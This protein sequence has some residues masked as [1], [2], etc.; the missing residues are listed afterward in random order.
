M[1]KNFPK[2]SKG[3]TFEFS[4]ILILSKG[5]TFHN[6][7]KLVTQIHRISQ[8]KA[9]WY[10]SDFCVRCINNVKMNK[11]CIFKTTASDFSY[12]YKILYLD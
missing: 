5:D 12:H 8:Q 7:F 10:E 2:L 9:A 11:N 6:R 3:N 1:C 4:M